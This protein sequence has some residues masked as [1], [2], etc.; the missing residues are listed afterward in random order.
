MSR[1][2][3]QAERWRAQEQ[4]KPAEH[5][6]KYRCASAEPWLSCR[7]DWGL[8]KRKEKKRHRRRIALARSLSLSLSLLSASLAPI[9]QKQQAS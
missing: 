5:Y 2:V 9:S 4:K 1:R 7:C 3:T 6:G 8:Q